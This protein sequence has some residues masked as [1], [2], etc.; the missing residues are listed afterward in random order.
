L[1]E[2]NVQLHHF[3]LLV[4]V[5]P[6]VSIS[7]LM[8]TVKGKCALKVFTRFPYETEATGTTI[9]GGRSIAWIRWVLMRM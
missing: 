7:Q 6:K 2:L 1:V 4:D 9:S 3:H 5:P 8:G